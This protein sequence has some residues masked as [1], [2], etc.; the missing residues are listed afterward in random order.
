MVT[1]PRRLLAS[2]LRPHRRSVV[3]YGLA[4]AAATALPLTSA[5]LLGSFARLAVRG[6]PYKELL[7]VGVLY[8]AIGLVSSVTTVLVTWRGTVLAWQVTNQ[9]RHDLAEYVLQADLSFHRDRTPGELVTRVDWDITLMTQF[10]ATVVAQVV[11]IG[12]LAGGTIVVAAV[13][14]PVLVPALAFGVALLAVVTYAMRNRALEET[15]AE[16]AAEAET[17]SA[18]EQY[19]AGCDD[20]ATLGAGLHGVARVGEFSADMVSASRHRGREQMTMQSSIKIAIS[21]AEVLIVAYGAFAMARG[22]IDVAAV[23]LGF[24]L[25]LLVANKVDHLTWRLQDA[26]GASGAA[27][28]VLELVAEHRLVESGTATLPAGPLDVC[29]EGTGLVYDDDEGNNAAISPLTLTFPAGRLV[30]VIGRTGSG[31]TSLARLLLRLVAPTS[32]QLTVGGVDLSTVTDADLRRRITAVPQDV[33]LFPGTVHDNVSMFSDRSAAEIIAALD[34]VGLGDW[35]RGLADGLDTRLAADDRDDGG[36]RVGLSAGQ[37]QLLALARALLREPSVVVLDE[38]TSRVDPATQEAIGRAMRR[39]VDGRTAMVIA[40][41][42]ET[43][44]ICDDIVMLAD[45]AIVEQG[46]R[47][48][49]A[50]NPSSRYAQLRAAGADAELEEL[51]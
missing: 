39:L 13:V 31:K 40:H 46:P 42:L 2:L 49:L 1:T 21:V 6:A 47:L 37:A 20:M 38:A 30:G 45:G 35:L 15:V 25:M 8:A 16:R 24:R 27:Q 29:F 22:S 26:Q 51:R 23:V 28:R 36:T 34:A 32:G 18:A 50:A 14:E 10:M 48:A 11:A 17:M 9:L 44:D 3:V 43:L 5:V 41:R 4:L 19:L 12:A 33:Q 7:P